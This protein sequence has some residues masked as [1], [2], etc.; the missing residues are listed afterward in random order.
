MGRSS[1]IGSVASFFPSQVPEYLVSHRTARPRPGPSLYYRYVPMYPGNLMSCASK[2]TSCFGTSLPTDPL[3][4]A[5][6]K[7]K[8][9][10]VPPLKSSPRISRP[11]LLLHGQSVLSAPPLYAGKK[12]R[13]SQAIRFAQTSRNSS[14]PRS[15]SLAT[16]SS[17][18]HRISIRPAARPALRRD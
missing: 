11:P 10:L 18:R 6:H 5:S 13:A 4:S 17:C 14:S 7:R 3:R 9:T 1:R 8:K 12:I 15:V 2:S 16:H